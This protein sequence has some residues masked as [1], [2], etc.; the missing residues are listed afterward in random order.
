MNER[1]KARPGGPRPAPRKRPRADLDRAGYGREEERS[2]T[3]AQHGQAARH[4][5][6]DY[7]WSLLGLGTGRKP[8]AYQHCL[9]ARYE[10]TLDK[11]PPSILV[12]Q[13]YFNPRFLSQL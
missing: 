8:T 4:S 13:N 9:S 1:A 6:K 11:A 7:A 3:A 2:E 10:R 5:V 12:V